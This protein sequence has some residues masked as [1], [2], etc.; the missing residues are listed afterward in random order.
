MS[1]LPLDRLD[2][3]YNGNVV[4]SI[5]AGKQIEPTASDWVY[6]SLSNSVF[7][8]DCSFGAHLDQPGWVLM[9]AYLRGQDGHSAVTNP[10]YLVT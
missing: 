6:P 2:V 3:V 9:V 7:R 5:E 8:F 10:V 1:L 4:R